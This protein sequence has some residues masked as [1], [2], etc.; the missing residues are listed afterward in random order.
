[1]QTTYLS[2]AIKSTKPTQL[3]YCDAMCSADGLKLDDVGPKP[4][5]GIP[6]IEGMENAWTI[7]CSNWD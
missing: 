2:D 3:R 7:S 6:K 4:E 5:T 1:M